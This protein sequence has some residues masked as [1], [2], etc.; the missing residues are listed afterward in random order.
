MFPVSGRPGSGLSTSSALISSLSRAN[1]CNN[2]F[3][4]RFVYLRR[5]GGPDEK[6]SMLSRDYQ[7]FVLCHRKTE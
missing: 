1:N 4:V 2:C 7:A 3:V 5:G 6:V